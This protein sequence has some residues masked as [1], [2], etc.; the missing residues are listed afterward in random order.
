MQED[1]V[2]RTV[3]ANGL[4]VL[5]QRMPAVRSVAVGIWVRAGSSCEAPNEHGLAHLLEHMVFTS[6]RSPRQIATR[7]EAVGGH[8]DAFTGR[9]LSCYYAVAMDRHLPRAVE[10]LADVLLHFR[11]TDDQLESEKRV[12]REEIRNV[13]DTP[14]DVAMDLFTELLWKGHPLGRPIMGTEA[15]VSGVRGEQLRTFWRTWYSADRVIAACA[16]NVEHGRFVRLCGRHLSFPPPDDSPRIRL[17]LPRHRPRVSVVDRDISQLHLCLGRTCPGYNHPDRLPLLALNAMLG[18]GMSSRLFQEAREKRGLAYA[19]FSTVTNLS[20]SG[21]V[22]TY[23]ATDPQAAALSLRVVRTEFRRLVRRGLTPSE[24]RCAKNQLKGGAV[25]A[26]ERSSSRM[27]RLAI[28][29]IYL[30]RHPTLDDTLRAIDA[31]TAEQVHHVAR[32]Y[33]D[34]NRL[35]L[36]VLGPNTALH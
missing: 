24:L 34:Q 22:V 32:K 1:P 15:S 6:R 4:T 10:L 8:V 12:V 5:S 21:L 27:T 23:L 19:I 16:G 11:F 33:L 9:E 31:V 17:R 14:D 30:G 28:D 25:L 36:L 7:L 20:T 29:E 35:S 26:H 13:N 3:L 2:Q 18:G